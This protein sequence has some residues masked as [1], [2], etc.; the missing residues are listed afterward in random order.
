MSNSPRSSL[1]LP[2]SLAAVEPVHDRII[3][4]APDVATNLI[5]NFLPLDF[6]E[7]ELREL[8]EEV[9]PIESVRIMKNRKTAKSKGYGF[10]KFAGHEDAKRAIDMFNGKNIQGKLIKVAFSRPGGTRTHCNLFVSNLPKKW[11]TKDLS[12][13]FG[14]F[15]K[16]LECRVLKN[17]NGESRRC[18]F[19]R[20]DA[21][22]DAQQ[23]LKSMDGYLP[24]NARSSINVKLAERPTHDKKK[25]DSKNGEAMWSVPVN[26]QDSGPYFPG[27]G[28]ERLP[29]M[30]FGVN[31]KNMPDARRIYNAEIEHAAQ[32]AINNKMGRPGPMG[33][34]PSAGPR[35]HPHAANAPHGNS[36][37]MTNL[38]AMNRMYVNSH[39]HL[40]PRQIAMTPPPMPTGHGYLA[41]SP[42]PNAP[43]LASQIARNRLLGN[44]MGFNH[45]GFPS[46]M[47][48]EHSIPVHPEYLQTS[49]GTDAFPSA[50][51][52]NGVNYSP[53]VA[54]AFDGPMHHHLRSRYI[55]TPSPPPSQQSIGAQNMRVHM[56]KD[57][58]PRQ[59]VP[60]SLMTPEGPG[61]HGS[62]PK[63]VG[64]DTIF[65][66][67]LPSV[68]DE[69]A[70]RGV[71][72]PY[73]EIKMVTLQRDN[74]G[75]SLGMAFVS[76]INPRNAQVAVHSLNGTMMYNSKVIVRL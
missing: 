66:S 6:K 28:G 38:N 42:T 13:H 43:F 62:V 4:L 5:I 73:G 74:T 71:C 55:A 32:I 67:G 29:P 37:Q 33:H 44:S 61:Q 56:Q 51:V 30:Y 40:Y 53:G 34:Q 22:I 9:G 11:D 25:Y 21:A 65:M 23:A 52:S 41:T 14:P 24:K 49:N 8:F 15:G 19:V 27:V 31:G 58:Q 46:G 63:G 64:K 75:N 26:S 76:F 16:L 12:I 45:G 7:S 36:S 57:A 17:N 1:I 50:P 35:M 54:E 72:L 18:G 48:R 10:V 39:A 60:V 69:D 68:F 20:F 47:I 70:I 2:E 3:A 59:P